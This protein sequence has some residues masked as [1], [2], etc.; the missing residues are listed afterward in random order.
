MTDTAKQHLAAVPDA[1]EPDELDA[2]REGLD[3]RPNGTVRLYIDG[4]RY[5]LRRPRAR[6]FRRLRESFQEVA[7]E[8]SDLSDEQDEWARSL[9]ERVDGRRR[10]DPNAGQTPAERRENRVRGRRLTEQVE[11]LMFGWWAEVVE[12]LE[13][14]NRTPVLAEPDEWPDDE[15]FDSFADLPMW[16]GTV[17]SANKIIAHWRSTPSLS[18][19]R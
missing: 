12:V 5:R 17:P 1:E 7:D 11:Q 9:A 13:V 2:V 16:M 6:E 18:G 14:D 19:G 10:D 8:I 4:N 15:P 3:L